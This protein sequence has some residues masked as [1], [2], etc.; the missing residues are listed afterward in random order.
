LSQGNTEEGYIRQFYLLWRVVGLDT[1]IL[2]SNSHT[3]VEIWP[4]VEFQTSGEGQP[5]AILTVDVH[6]GPPY[7]SMRKRQREMDN[8]WIGIFQKRR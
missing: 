3:S 5:L 1:G 2:P 4:I 7:Q 6:H 8:S